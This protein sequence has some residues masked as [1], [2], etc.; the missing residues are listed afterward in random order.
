MLQEVSISF[1]SAL[2]H[3]KSRI[4]LLC[5]LIYKSEEKINI[6]DS[7]LANKLMV[8]SIYEKLVLFSFFICL[9]GVFFIEFK[10]CS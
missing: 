8:N 1:S 6:L 5:S 10:I 3:V 9:Y 2:Q 7:L 4:K